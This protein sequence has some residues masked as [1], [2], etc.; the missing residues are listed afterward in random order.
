MLIPHRSQTLLWYNQCN[1]GYDKFQ[2]SFYIDEEDRKDGWYENEYFFLCVYCF[3]IKYSLSGDA[4]NADFS[5]IT[6]TRQF[7]TIFS[8]TSTQCENLVK[9]VVF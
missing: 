6:L 1:G 7:P 2:R 9:K 4:K 5:H 8:N 3:Q